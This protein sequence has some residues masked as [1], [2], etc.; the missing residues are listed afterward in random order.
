VVELKSEKVYLRALEPEDLEFLY[1]LE[2][3]TQFW[4]VSGTQQ[5]YS[6]H[7]LKQYLENAHRDIYEVKQMRMAICA[8]EGGLVGLIDL[9]DFDPKHL[10]VGLGVVILTQEDRNKGMGAE[11]VELVTSFA[12]QSL[13]VRQVYA[14]VLED[15]K[16]SVHLFE[17]LGFTRTGIKKEWIRSDGKFKDQYLYQKFNPSCT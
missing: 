3:D 8:A 9:F 17:K 16:A 1:L 7:V 4:E 12:F 15:N 2:N 14:H 13:D 6:R 10:R 5:P 11:A